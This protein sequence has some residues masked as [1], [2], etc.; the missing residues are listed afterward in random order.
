[1]H[2]NFSEATHLLFPCRPRWRLERAVLV[3]MLGNQIVQGHVDTRGRVLEL[4]AATGALWIEMPSGLI[5]NSPPGASI[6]INGAAL[7][8]AATVNDELGARVQV[9]LPPEILRTT[10]LRSLKAG[11]AVNIEVDLLGKY[12]ERILSAPTEPPTPGWRSDSSPLK[13][14]RVVTASTVRETRA[15]AVCVLPPT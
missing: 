14:N 8:V 6:A 4:D 3:T 5:R 7:R 2:W 15:E 1:M 9:L 10:T 12:A 11:H 13:L